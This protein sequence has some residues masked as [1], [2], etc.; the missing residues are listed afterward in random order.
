MTYQL[1][2]TI[3]LVGMM[4][5]GKTVIGRGLARKLNASFIDLD[6]EIVKSANLEINE[7]FNTF[8]EEFFREKE[9]R[10]LERLILGPPLVLATGGGTVMSK[11]NL[12]LILNETLSIWL[13]SSPKIIWDRIKD[14]KNRPLVNNCRDFSDFNKIYKVRE[15]FYKMANISILNDYDY[16]I[17]KMIEKAFESF[18]NYEQISYNGRD[19]N[20]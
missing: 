20:A 16:T 8:G 12:S 11:K 6:Q 19:K 9:E 18:N 13:N 10:V 1:N 5:S 4:G 7:I 2:Q 17:D 3:A 15:K 14:K